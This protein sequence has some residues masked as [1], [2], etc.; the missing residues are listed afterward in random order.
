MID[1]KLTC[2]YCKRQVSTLDAVVAHPKC[3]E[4]LL[5]TAVKSELMSDANRS[6][7]EFAEFLPQVSDNALYLPASWNLSTVFQP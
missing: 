7:E 2:D 1:L 6:T 3:F 5:K 4:D